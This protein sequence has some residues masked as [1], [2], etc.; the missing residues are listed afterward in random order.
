MSQQFKE[1]HMAKSG[2]K[3]GIIGILIVAIIVIAAV[4]FFYGKD[5]RDGFE[6]VGDAIGELPRGTGEAAEQLGDRSPADK[7]ADAVGDAVQDNK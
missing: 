2:S 5:D 4:F 1:N 3:N 6:R 7:A